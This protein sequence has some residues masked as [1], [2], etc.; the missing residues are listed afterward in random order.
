MVDCNCLVTRWYKIF[1]NYEVSK[2]LGILNDE[3]VDQVESSESS[4]FPSFLAPPAS[5][6]IYL[7][8][9]ISPWATIP[10]S[11]AEGVIKLRSIG[12]RKLLRVHSFVRSLAWCKSSAGG[13]VLYSFFCCLHATNQ[14]T[15]TAW[16]SELGNA[17]FTAPSEGYP[18]RSEAQSSASLNMCEKLQFWKPQFCSMET[19]NII[20]MSKIGFT[21][22]TYFT[23]F[24][25]FKTGKI[26]R[27]CYFF[28]DFF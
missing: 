12:H 25:M 16:T 10:E 22:K 19:Q 20:T 11:I 14:P 28:S 6:C 7:V 13:F 21:H 27:M 24:V 9:F 23:T 18:R 1:K 17:H 15:A 5:G 26:S 2:I 3:T 8:F 4:S